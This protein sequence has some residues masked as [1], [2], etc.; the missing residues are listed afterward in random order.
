MR[1]GL[2]R[3]LPTGIHVRA[4]VS[5]GARL[6]PS[7]DRSGEVDQLAVHGAVQRRV[8]L[9]RDCFQR[10]ND[11]F[12]QADSHAAKREQRRQDGGG[13]APERIVYLGQR[14]SLHR[15]ADGLTPR[16]APQA[17]HFRR[18]TVAVSNL[19]P[20]R[21][22]WR[23]RQVR[24]LAQGVGLGRDEKERADALL[25]CHGHGIGYI[26]YHIDARGSADVE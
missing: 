4:L 21:A 14:P 9:G 2:I 6:H 17:A 3:L 1:P 16:E 15:R 7:G 8:V 12:R 11:V 13:I 10:E 22:S 20:Q 19:A 24:D 5:G 23:I 25:S 26:L 18:V